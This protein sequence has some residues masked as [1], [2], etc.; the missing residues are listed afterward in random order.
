MSASPRGNHIRV[1]ESAG[2]GFRPCPPPP[3]VGT[4][5]R[6]NSRRL[7][8]R[9]ASAGRSRRVGAGG[10]PSPV[11]GTARLSFPQGNG[12]VDGS[13]GL[14]AAERR[15]TY[16]PSRRCSLGFPVSPRTAG[17]GR[18]PPKG[19]RG[20]R[21]GRYGACLRDERHRHRAGATPPPSEATPICRCRSERRKASTGQPGRCRRGAGA[22]PLGGGRRRYRDRDREHCWGNTRT[23]RR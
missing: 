11:R 17:P 23:R 16:L 12:T 8:G 3:G 13:Q 7:G 19:G 20:S 5:C 15:G 6:T 22:T 2:I 18:G 14:P 1:R 10:A 21:A 4:G 9:L